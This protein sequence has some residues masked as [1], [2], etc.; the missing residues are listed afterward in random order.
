MEIPINTQVECTDGICGHSVCVLINPVNDQVTHLVVKT[1]S[2]PNAEYIVPVE[3]M[4]ETISDTI[5]LNCSQ[6]DL[7]MMDP[8]IKTAYIEEQVP[9]SDYRQNSGLAQMGSF[10]YQPYVIPEKTVY[11]SVENQQIPPGELALHRS[12][13]V[14]ATDGDVGHVDE[15]VVSPENGKITHL[16]MREGHLWGQ[17]EVIIP[18]SAI[19]EI[20]GD[21]VFLKLD[22]HQID[23]LPT[24]PLHRRWA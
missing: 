10:Y 15:F 4:A 20:R 19:E 24:F 14:E 22:K 3:L 5:R 2:S 12:A 21:M 6:A 1:D 8:F 9:E 18:L 17:K 16:V 7:E 23:D 13:R 11:E